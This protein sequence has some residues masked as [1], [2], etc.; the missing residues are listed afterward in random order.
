MPEFGVKATNIA[1]ADVKPFIAP[2]VETRQ[3]TINAGVA[4]AQM[5]SELGSQAVEAY[6]GYQLADLEKEQQKNVDAYMESKK[7]PSIAAEAQLEAASQRETVD[8][9]WDNFD[10]TIEDVNPIERE[11]Q[12]TLLKYKTAAEQGVM[13]PEELNTRILKTTRE[14]VAKNPGL[15]PELLARSQRVLEL[16]GIQQV[17]KLDQAIAESQQKQQQKMLDNIVQL[18]KEK[19]I[20]V[21]YNPDGSISNIGQVK[22]QIDIVQQQDFAAE[23]VKRTTT[24]VTEQ[25]KLQGIQFAKEFGIAGANG[26]IN[27][28]SANAREVFNGAGDYAQKVAYAR[29]LFNAVRQTMGEKTQGISHDPAVKEVIDYTEKQLKAI[30]E[31]LVNFKSGEDAAKY[32]ENSVAMLRHEGFIRVTQQTGIDP[33]TLRTVSGFM[34]GVIGNKVIHGNEKLAN[35]LVDTIA[36]M[37]KGVTGGLGTDVTAKDHTGKPASTN[38]IGHSAKQVGNGDVAAVHTLNNTILTVSSELANP[39]KFTPT[40]E[41]T[42]QKFLFFDSYMQELGKEQ[43]KTGLAQISDTARSAASTNLAEYMDLTLRD[44]DKQIKA[45]EAS[46]VKVVWNALPDGR[47]SVETSDPRLTQLLTQNYVSRVNWG[48][49]AFANLQGVDKKQAASTFYPNYREYFGLA[50]GAGR[51]SPQEI[52]GQIKPARRSTDLQISPEEQAARDAK[53]TAIRKSEGFSD[54]DRVALEKEIGRKTIN[55]TAK[56]I[57]IREWELNTGRKWGK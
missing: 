23:Q 1:P 4:Q 44:M 36:N 29:N 33:D 30:E 3:P 47:I 35:K 45:A 26:L 27:E 19:N 48:L 12:K 25:Q 5:W 40:P 41:G 9:L 15:Y 6:K 17:V 39:E 2:G 49:G 11:F 55:P 28:A 50:A 22:Q 56:A 51:V 38:F 18:A 34:Q 7:N 13:S 24:A 37:A 14:A 8:K 42:S 20:P 16:S 43:N 54:A 53:A 57:L 32:L 46:G 31:N 21:Q 52:V 10:A